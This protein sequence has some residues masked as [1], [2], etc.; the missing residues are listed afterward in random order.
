VNGGGLLPLLRRQAERLLLYSVFSACTEHLELRAAF[1]MQDSGRSGKK[2]SRTRGIGL[3]LIPTY[4]KTYNY[5][6]KTCS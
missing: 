1:P 5:T 2:V 6:W 4:N 3:Q